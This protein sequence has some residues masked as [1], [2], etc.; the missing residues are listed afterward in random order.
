[1]TT[2]LILGGY[3]NTGRPLARHLLAHTKANLLIG[4]RQLNKARNFANELN[5]PRANPVQVDAA[6]ETSL[7]SALRG[8]D[9]CLLAAPTTQSTE[10]VVRACLESGAD[11]LDVQFGGNKLGILKGLEAEIL[12]AG[13]CF[14]T[15]AG[16][17]P[18]LPS[19]LVRHAATQL[20]SIE[21]ALTSGW[22]N[23]EPIPYTESVDELVEAFKD[24]DARVFRDGVWGKR[25]SYE[26]RKF[27]FGPGI[28]R[29]T[30]YSMY[31]EELGAMPAMF[32][33]LKETGFYISGTNLLVDT[34]I[35]PIVMLGLKVFPRRGVRPLGKLVWWSMT[36]FNKPPFG[37]VLCVEAKGQRNG[38][39]ARVRAQVGHADG[40]ELTAIPVAAYLLQ[41]LDGTARK[42]GLWMMGHLAEPRRLMKDM[43]AMGAKVE[44]VVE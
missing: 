18:G 41:Y 39:P 44:T 27:D 28:G 6:E 14:V 4:G 30:C 24:Y 17:H 43:Q 5:D 42:P 35:T 36:A 25:G 22:L 34:L 7:R 11:Y 40:Y 2:I 12:K 38:K 15:E 21:S 31:F 20:D 9:L 23:I 8:V 33:G 26:M 16:F 10:R 29:K 13:R 3:G 32:P 1:M 19:A 37:V